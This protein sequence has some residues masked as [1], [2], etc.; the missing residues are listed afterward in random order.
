MLEQAR[1]RGGVA[2][3][4]EARVVWGVVGGCQGGAP[5]GGAVGGVDEDVEEDAAL[6][7]V[8]ERGSGCG[9]GGSA[10]VG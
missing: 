9:R 6:C 4:E 3:D 5:R 10:R 8:C 1:G 7:A 2:F